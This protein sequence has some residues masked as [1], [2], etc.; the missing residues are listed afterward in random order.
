MSGANAGK[1]A[2]QFTM[3]VII[4]VTVY[5]AVNYS[6]EVHGD[7]KRY[8]STFAPSMTRSSRCFRGT[9]AL[10]RLPHI[11]LPTELSARSSQLLFSPERT[12][13]KR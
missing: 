12:A 1:L 8:K 11:C 4:R 2:A 10:F 7:G 9:F 3:G 5:G 13:Q 6:F